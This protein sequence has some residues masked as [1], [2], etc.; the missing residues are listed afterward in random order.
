MQRHVSIHTDL[1]CTRCTYN[2][3]GLARCGSCPECAAPIE[4]STRGVLLK[5]SDPRWLAT[6]R[7]GI[8]L[9]LWNIPIRTVVLLPIL[10]PP[11]MS[12]GVAIAAAV[13]TLAGT[14]CLLCREPRA[15]LYRATLPWRAAIIVCATVEL[16]SGLGPLVIALLPHAHWMHWLC[17]VSFAAGLI[18]RLQYLHRYDH[19]ISD[20]D[21]VLSTA[22]LLWLIGVAML[23]L[24]PLI[25]M[26]L[27]RAT[28]QFGPFPEELMWT[29]MIIAAL[30]WIVIA[31][32]RYL[33]GF[34]RGQREAALVAIALA[35]RPAETED[36]TSVPA[37]GRSRPP[38]A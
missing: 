22:V 25:F 11:T 13:L 30:L 33:A 34:R 6:V 1:P 32:V 29:V 14:A 20:A 21:L 35:E 2:L 17:A 26:T 10:L 24:A 4:H 28:H 7:W 18:A 15:V 37:Q 9:T 16:L 31:L 12:F 3:R 38:P 19:R 5:Y 23:C 36:G 27:I 8:A